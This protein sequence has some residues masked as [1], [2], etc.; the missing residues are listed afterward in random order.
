MA[1][2]GCDTWS[3]GLWAHVIEPRGHHQFDIVF[4]HKR[5][6]NMSYLQRFGRVSLIFTLSLL[7]LICSC[8]KFTDIPNQAPSVPSLGNPGMS[9]SPTL[10]WT[11]SDPEG[12][13]LIYDVYFGNVNIVDTTFLIT[14]IFA[15]GQAPPCADE[16]DANGDNSVNIADITFIIARIFAG[17]PAPVCGTT[18]T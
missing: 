7:L 9:L 16:G 14:R 4:V 2:G 12:D 5:E 6:S 18:G 11:S 1:F 15:G 8:D 10:S 13:P 3:W 17:G